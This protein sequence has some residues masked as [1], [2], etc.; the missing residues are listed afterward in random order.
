[1]NMSPPLCFTILSPRTC[2]IDL[3][4]DWTNTAPRL[5]SLSACSEASAREVLT[6]IFDVASDLVINRNTAD[7][8]LV[9]MKPG[10]AVTSKVLTDDRAKNVWIADHT[11]VSIWCIKGG[12]NIAWRGDVDC[13]GGAI[14]W[15]N[16]IKPQVASPAI[17][18]RRGYSVDIVGP[19]GAIDIVVHEIVPLVAEVSGKVNLGVD[20]CAEGNIA[21]IAGC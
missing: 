13:L 2:R 8:F 7:D 21:N 20:P 15:A 1:M 11:Q 5:R 18:S 14:C 3:R 6:D 9:I 19:G 10:I 16:A 12:P 4:C 17:I